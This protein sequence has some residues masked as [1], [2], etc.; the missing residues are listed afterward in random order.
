MKELI[1][2]IQ[3]SVVPTKTIEKSKSKIADLA[4]KL[5]ENEIAKYPEVIRIRIW[6]V[7]CKG[8]MAIKRCRCRYFC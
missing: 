7:L 5:V 8:N 1:S 6:R 3:K 2:K 4:F